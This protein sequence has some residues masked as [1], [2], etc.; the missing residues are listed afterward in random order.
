ML[1][2]EP[3][4]VEVRHVETGVLTQVIQ[5]NN[6]RLLFAETPPSTTHSKANL[7]QPPASNGYS[8]GAYGYDTRYGAYNDRSSI[9]SAHSGSM[10]IHGYQ[11]YGSP[12]APGAYPP[13]AQSSLGRREIIMASDD[14]IMSLQVARPS[15]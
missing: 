3:T 12:T 7:Y 5:G 13:R 6:L 9:Y 8:A 10:P 2:F 11:G 15:A 1:A 14:R 4:F